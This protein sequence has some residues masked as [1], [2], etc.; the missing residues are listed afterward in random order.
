[1]PTCDWC[2]KE[3]EKVYECWIEGGI[4]N[5]CE[6]CASRAK[7]IKTP[8]KQ[9]TKTTKIEEEKT[10]DIIP[11]YNEII[12][13]LIEKNNMSVEEFAKKLG[14]K[15]SYIRKILNKELKPDLELA[16]K[17]EHDFKVRLI[18]EITDEEYE[19][20]SEEISWDDVIRVR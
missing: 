12:K 6:D 3:V 18:V 14:V 1:M 5:L 20:T 7:I 13:E 8:I 15:E 17:I 11:N 9:V 4:V 16:K 10:I 2:G 19:E